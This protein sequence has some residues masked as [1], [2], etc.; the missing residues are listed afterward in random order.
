MCISQQ[1]EM[2]QNYHKQT[3]LGSSIRVRIDVTGSED[4][5]CPAQIT[6]TGSCGESLNFELT[7]VAI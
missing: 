3:L 4:G 2:L 7:A 1:L 6:I 5:S